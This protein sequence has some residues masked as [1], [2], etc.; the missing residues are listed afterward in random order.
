VKE[1]TKPVE[2][3]VPVKV[4]KPV[5]KAEDARPVQSTP[6]VK[7]DTKPVESVTPVKVE[8][9]VH[10]AP[11]EETE[12]I[13]ADEEKKAEVESRP[14]VCE[15]GPAVQT[16]RVTDSKSGKP[17][18]GVEVSIGGCMTTTD[19]NGFYTLKN[20]AESNRAVINFKHDGYYENSKVILIKHYSTGTEKVSPNYLEYA[21]DSIDTKKVID[22]Q[23]HNTIS[24]GVNANVE[25]D[26]GIVTDADGEVYDGRMIVKL[27]YGNPFNQKDKFAF[28]GLYEGKNE[29][30]ETILFASYGYMSIALEDESGHSLGLADDMIV[31]FPATG[32]IDAESIPIWYY[33]YSKGE[34]I[35]EGYAVRQQDGTYKGAVS[36]TGTWSINMPLEEAPGIY[37]A[38]V[39]YESGNPVK[40]ARVEAVGPNW[41]QSDLTTDAEGLFEIK[42]IPDED[43]GLRA[44]NY[45]WKY[46]AVYNGRIEAIESGD[47][48]EDRK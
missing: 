31:T 35:E 2:S 40:D 43:F 23:M 38:H 27:A 29:N 21:I 45:K 5:H 25:L 19:E 26:A 41:I 30:G 37:R 13:S 6:V 39:I 42:V 22:S 12:E 16:G 20:I 15:K 7:E 10:V 24:A 11:V 8:K 34:W 46:G 18:A 48:V 9:P 33:D 36:R 14:L 32:G 47:I 44:Y 28:P 4:E 17:L 1:G 3:V